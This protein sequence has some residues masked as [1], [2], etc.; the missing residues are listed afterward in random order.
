MPPPPPA[1]MV[2]SSGLTLRSDLVIKDGG[3]HPKLEALIDTS[4]DE[5]HSIYEHVNIML[6]MLL[7]YC[8]CCL[9][10]MLWH[11]EVYFLLN[12]LNVWFNLNENEH[13]NITDLL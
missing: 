3:E 7:S 1:T 9:I 13:L 4:V 5:A 12:W 10:Q 8:Q 2:E 11:D 6:D